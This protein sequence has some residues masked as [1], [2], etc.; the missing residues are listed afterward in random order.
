MQLELDEHE[1]PEHLRGYFEVVETPTLKAKNAIGMPWRLALA[2]QADG[3]ILRSEI[4]WEKPS[5]MPESV[6][7]RPTRSH[8]Q[9]FLF[10]KSPRYYFDATAVRESAADWGLRDRTFGKFHTEGLRAHGQPPHRGMHHSNFARTGRNARTVWRIN[11]E[12]LTGLQHYAAFPTELV[13]RCLKAGC[14]PGGRVLDPF[15]GS[16]TVGLV[17]REL[18][19]DAVCLDLSMPYLRDIARE[20]IGLAA[21]HR[22]SHGATTRTES[23]EDLPLFGG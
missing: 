21:L 19:H 17:A 22:W 7:D 4:I 10:A 9:L 20:R 14:P 16:G 3:W 11:P 12:P 15:A 8:E 2:L 5:C 18:G 13:R 23:Y 6:Q 1:I